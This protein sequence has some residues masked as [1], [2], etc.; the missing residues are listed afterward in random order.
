MATTR[1]AD[2][3][4]P[5]VY[6][7]Y[8]S[9]DDPETT[10][11][12]QAGIVARSEILDTIARSG[13]KTATVPFWKDLD[14]DIEPNYSNDDPS[15]EAEANKVTSGSMTARKVFVNQGFGDMDLVQE[16]AG[17]SPMQH[18][19]ARF[20]TYW[21]RQHQRRLIASCMGLMAD[22][23]ANDGSDMTIDISGEAGAGAVFNA[24]AFVDAY[25]TMGQWA[26]NLAAMYIHT[27]IMRQMVKAD[28][29]EYIPDSE[30]K[31][32]IPVYRRTIRVI[33]ETNPAL[34]SNGVYTSIIFG[35]GSIGWGGVGGN[36]FAEGEGIPRVPFELWR[37]PHA[38]NGGGME[39]IWE[40]HTWILHPLG[41]SWLEPAGSPGLAEFS[42]SL[43]DLRQAQ[44]WDRVVDRANVPLAFVKSRAAP[45]ASPASP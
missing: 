18:I 43:A 10:L 24:D 14:A 35:S 11:F 19:R 44:Y 28:D 34:V 39:E 27:D 1:L 31:L 45:V 3:F 5:E 42:P 17:S 4:I 22:N 12:Y 36:V 40:R 29:I 41:F 2:A 26:N 38:G 16:L 15:D 32:T 23:V 21:Q 25:Y 33:A 13:G 20:G 7:T 37:N 8:F 30:G 6:G 9:V